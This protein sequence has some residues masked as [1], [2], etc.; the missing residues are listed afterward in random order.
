MFTAGRRLE[1]S[2][3]CD[4]VHLFQF[5]SDGT[6]SMLKLRQNRSDAKMHVSLKHCKGDI[7]SKA[8]AGQETD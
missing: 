7:R 5:T 1:L 4:K 6:C 2:G 3:E 8:E